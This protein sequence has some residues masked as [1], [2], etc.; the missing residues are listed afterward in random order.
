MSYKFLALGSRYFNP[1]PPCGGRLRGKPNSDHLAEISIHAPRAGGDR[2]QVA[3][4][5]HLLADFNPRPP[6]GGRPSILQMLTHG[7]GI[8]IHAPRAGGDPCRIGCPYYL[9]NFNPRPPCGGRQDWIKCLLLTSEISIHAPRA[10]GD[11]Y[12]WDGVNSK[13]VF[14][15]TPPVRGATAAE[16]ACCT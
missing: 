1:R 15:S 11:I 9:Y 6:C 13:W 7:D 12:I 10:G 4:E 5:Q 2:P 14:Q 16:P 3:G 8:S